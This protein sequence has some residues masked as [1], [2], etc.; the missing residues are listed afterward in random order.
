MKIMPKPPSYRAL[1]S[2]VPAL[3][4][5][6]APLSSLHQGLRQSTVPSTTSRPASIGRQSRRPHRELPC[7]YSSGSD[8]AA[9]GLEPPD[10]PCRHAASVCW[11][12]LAPPSIR[13]QSG[14]FRLAY[15]AEHLDGLMTAPLG[16]LVDCP[17]V[18][19]GSCGVET[20]EAKACRAALMSPVRAASNRRSR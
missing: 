11:Q 8:G 15:R 4:Q 6:I 16:H 1:I 10:R 20:P 9:G 17:A 19:V 3:S 5:T 14:C 12:C 13:R 7:S 18:A 2:S